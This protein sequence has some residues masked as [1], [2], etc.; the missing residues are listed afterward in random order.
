MSLYD[1]GAGRKPPLPS[2]QLAQQQPSYTNYN[3]ND[4]YLQ[5]QPSNEI[6]IVETI[7]NNNNGIGEIGCIILSTDLR[8][9]E[10][11]SFNFT[12]HV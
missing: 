11:F 12:V 8:E 2:N 4:E 6:V 3:N 5:Q 9:K 10:S 7:P 1:S